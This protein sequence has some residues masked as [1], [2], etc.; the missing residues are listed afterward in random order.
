M[1]LGQSPLIEWGAVASASVEIWVNVSQA[2]YAI[3]I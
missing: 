3:L 1:V 2:L